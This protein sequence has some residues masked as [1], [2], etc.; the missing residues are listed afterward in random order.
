[1][2]SRPGIYIFE[3]K[4]KKPLYIGKSISLKSRLKQHYEGFKNNS[5][6]AKV[7]IPQ[8]KY[9]HL[10][11]VNNDL[12]AIIL[13][14]N[15]IRSYKPRY[16][17]IAK[18]GK[19]NVYIIFT[20]TPDSKIK[21]IHATDISSLE[22]DDFTKQVYGP[23][24]STKIAEIILRQVRKIFGFCLSPYNSKYRTCFNYHIE[25][26]PGA[27]KYEITPKNYEY[28][29]KKIKKFLSGHFVKLNK[30]LHSQIKQAIKNEK[31]EEANRLK[32]QI[33]GL[34]QALTNKNSSLLLKLSD[35]SDQLQYMIANTLKHPKLKKPPRRI[36]CYD[37]AHLQGENY[38]GSMAVFI[39]S[40]P[41]TSKYRHFHIKGKQKSDPYAMKEIISRRL[42]HSEW[43]IPDLIVLD[44]GIPQLSTVISIIPKNIAVIAL[45]KKRETIYFYD[46]NNSLV[47]IN[48]NIEDPVLNVFRSIRDESHRFATT[49]HKRQRQK[50]LFT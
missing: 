24:T 30:S 11:I 10:K 41:E 37:L 42:N 32:L 31:Y 49:F 46:E 15:Y 5:T 16:N 1:V 38:V 20:N 27:C 35:A 44:G 23:F 19:S 25:Q 28:H 13:E 3:D 43:G 47:S 8:T 29:L 12:E 6:K 18:D 40:Q 33:H 22:L 2:P 48:L 36:E 9:I 21:I 50:S 39:N 26:C 45:A 7:F 14:S 4:N 17:A 34:E